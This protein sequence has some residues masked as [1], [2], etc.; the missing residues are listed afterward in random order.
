M[1]PVIKNNEAGV[2]G[3]G[4][5][6]EIGKN[7]YG[8]QFQDEIIVV[9][10]GIKFPE[11]DLLGIDYVIP[12]YSYLIQNAN[13]VKALIITHGH[14]DHIGGIPFLL[15]QINIPIYA[16]PLALALISNKLEEHGLLRDAELHEINEDTVIKFRKTT[17]SF[18]R[19]TH[20]LSLIHI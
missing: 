9:D 2:F 18:F 5:L 10:A 19:T 8:V 13:K 4:G 17:I 15:K 20:S 6:G 11:D 7:M 14:E 16:T 3:I 12:D 1:K